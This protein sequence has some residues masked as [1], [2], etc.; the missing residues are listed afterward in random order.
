MLTQCKYQQTLSSLF[1]C[2]AVLAS[3]SNQNKWTTHIG[4]S[5]D[6]A[7]Y[8]KQLTATAYYALYKYYCCKTW[9]LCYYLISLLKNKVA[10]IYR[11]SLLHMKETIW[12][13]IN[14]LP[15]FS[16]TTIPISFQVLDS[17]GFYSPVVCSL[18]TAHST[19]LHGI[20]DL[21]LPLWN[22]PY[23]FISVSYCSELGIVV[24]TATTH[25][26]NTLP[27]LFILFLP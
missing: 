13:S 15:V 8:V 25:T 1:Q 21:M 6:T 18:C 22:Q 17:E 4:P 27:T 24:S 23:V 16:N 20:T 9:H 3:A 12:L 14:L 10:A 2:S 26:Y 19:G 11:S 5:L 7:I